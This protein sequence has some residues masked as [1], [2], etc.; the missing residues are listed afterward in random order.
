M[1]YVTLPTSAEGPAASQASSVPPEGMVDVATWQRTQADLMR[2]QELVAQVGRELA[3]PLTA[4]LER[5]NALMST[6]RIDRAGLKSLLS[7]M[8]R[9][10]QA[11]IWCQ[12]ISRLSSGRARQSHERVHLT[13]T[14]QSVLAHRAR[15][16]QADAPMLFS[17]LN[18]LVDW[19]LACAHGAIDLRVD[20]K[21]WPAHGQLVLR[22]QHRPADLSDGLKNGEVPGAVNGLT[23]HLID[24]IA[25][26]MGLKVERQVDASTLNL[27]LE[28]P[29]TINPL[30]APDP[31]DEPEQEGFATSLNSKPLAGSHILVVAARRDLRL[32]IRESVKSM[33]LIVDF[34]SSVGEATQFCREALPH[35]IIFESSLRGQ[36]FDQLI[37]S[38]RQEV[39]DFVMVE[40]LEEG[41]AFDISS[42]SPNGVARVGR[43]A[44]LTS[45]PSA[46]VYELARVM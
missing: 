31:V 46:L 15:E 11:G 16:V 3:E 37:A 38:I 33:G 2:F 40:V 10:R 32:L 24:Q 29:H 21:P 42:I 7:E 5:V 39:P 1:N 28:F 4:A 41:S 35:A 36:R 25:Q 9:A 6:G 22:L 8:D 18:G 12:Q 34:V 23:W 44:V 19:W 20:I 43:E 26:T 30:L 13:N 45:L 27:V 14:I 17:L